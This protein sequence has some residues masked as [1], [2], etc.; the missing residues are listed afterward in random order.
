V[1]VLA[2]WRHPVKAMLGEALSELL[3]RRVRLERSDSRA[4]GRFASTGAHHDLAPHRAQHAL[5]TRDAAI[6]D[7]VAALQQRISTE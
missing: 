3:G 2:I 5:P 1:G 6:A 7:A 4:E